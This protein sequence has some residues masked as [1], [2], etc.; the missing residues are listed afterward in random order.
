MLRQS[1]ELKRNDFLYAAQCIIDLFPFER[2]ET[3]YI[4]SGNSSRFARGKLVDK[5]R[6]KRNSLR[7]AGVIKKKRNDTLQCET[8]SVPCN[9]EI[10][11]KK[12]WLTHNIEPWD[13]VILFWKETASTRANSLLSSSSNL[14]NI[15]N[16]W[17]I[18]K[19]PHG[20]HLVEIDF[21]KMYKEKVNKLFEI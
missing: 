15:F 16:D 1:I 19:H 4:P 8:P 13:K 14:K 6:N 7:K 11:E 20:Y 12:T 2:K 9:E 10:L 21:E 18:S 17:P 3:Y 5:Y